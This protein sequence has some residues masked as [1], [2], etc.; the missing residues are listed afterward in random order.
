M[1]ITSCPISLAIG[2]KVTLVGEYRL[3]K[4]LLRI[5]FRAEVQ[6]EFCRK[7]NLGGHRTA[8]Q[9]LSSKLYLCHYKTPFRPEKVTCRLLP[10]R[11]G[12]TLFRPAK[13]GSEN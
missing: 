9:D 7:T 4:I 10:H 12:F 13:E 3:Q 5:S 1:R 2:V 8:L 6:R 11:S